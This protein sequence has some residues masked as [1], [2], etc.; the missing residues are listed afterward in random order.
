MSIN[1]CR[2][3]E[4]RENHHLATTIVISISCKELSMNA[5]LAGKTSMETSHLHSFK[6]FSYKILQ[7]EKYSN[8]IVQSPGR[9]YLSQLIKVNIT[10]NGTS[11]RHRVPPDI[12]KAQ[13]H[14]CYASPPKSLT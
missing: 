8:F 6:I 9:R 2:R 10:C 13:H 5:K 7:R 12:K 11:F 3:N 4:E 1:K 14:S